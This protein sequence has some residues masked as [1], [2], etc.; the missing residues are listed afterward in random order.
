MRDADGA[1]RGLRRADRRRLPLRRLPVRARSALGRLPAPRG[2]LLLPAGRGR[3][4]IPAQQ[5]ALS[6]ADWKKLLWLAHFDKTARLRRYAAHYLATTGQVYWSDTHQLS[7][8]ID[9]YHRRST[10][11]SAARGRPRSSA[12]LYVPR[13]GWRTSC[14]RRP[15]TSRLEADVIYGTIRLIERDDESF[16]AWAKEPYACID[17][18]PAR[19][20]HARGGSSARPTLPPPDRHRRSARRQLLP[21]VSPL[22]DARAV[23]PLLSAV[24]GV[25]ARQARVRPGRAFQ[26]DWY[27]WLGLEEA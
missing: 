4:P 22:G 7:T 1:R 2:L 12:E 24:P 3:H 16:L 10:R 19:R 14:R 11:R 9:D 17:L 5:R 21:D 18:Q 8:Y 26:S 25:P 27:R 23:E 13:A 15:T 6:A 20:P